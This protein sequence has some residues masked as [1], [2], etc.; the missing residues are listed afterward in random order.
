MNRMTAAHNYKSLTE[1]FFLQR[2]CY[3]ILISLYK[4]CR[5]KTC[6]V[7]QNWKVNWS[8]TPNEKLQLR[9]KKIFENNVLNYIS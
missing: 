4:M 2:F 9:K 8:N 3:I 6:R 5:K 7:D 1:H